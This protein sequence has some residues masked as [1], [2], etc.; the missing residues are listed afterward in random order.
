MAGKVEQQQKS[1]LQRAKEHLGAE[2]A[3]IIGSDFT[4][5]VTLNLDINQGGVGS[6]ETVVRRRVR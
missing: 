3:G 6:F 1:K 2:L 5:Q 4:G